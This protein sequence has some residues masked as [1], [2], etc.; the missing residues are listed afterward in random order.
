MR[1]ASSVALVAL[2]AGCGPSLAP[3]LVTVEIHERLKSC[4]AEPAFPATGVTYRELLSDYM[5]PLR[6]AGRDCRATLHE[7]V[8]ALSMEEGH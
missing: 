4:E 2:L 3:E 7:L 6:R 1:F 5:L 8:E